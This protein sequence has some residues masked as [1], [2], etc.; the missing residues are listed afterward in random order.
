MS[1]KVINV[2]DGRHGW[3]G[4]WETAPLHFDAL[5]DADIGRTVIYR[6]FGRAEAGT[7]SSFRNGKVW[8]RYSRGDT[9]AAAN[10]DDLCF[11]I[12]PL[13]G[14]LTRGQKRPRT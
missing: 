6:D 13:D 10:A 1:E 12:C 7:L 4:A 9:A 5:T 2:V 11:G 14:D 8:A 3:Q